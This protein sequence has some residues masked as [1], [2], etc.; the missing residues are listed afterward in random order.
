MAKVKSTIKEAVSKWN[1]DNPT[2]RKKTLGSLASDLGISTS[3]LSQIDSSSQFQKYLSV[4]FESD[5]KFEQM[6]VFDLYAKVDIPIIKKLSK[7]KDVLECEIYHLVKID[8]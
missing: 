1:S 7:I 3:A 4:V 5:V 8:E 6:T 2:L